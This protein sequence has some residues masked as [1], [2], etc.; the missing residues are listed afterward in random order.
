[1]LRSTPEVFAPTNN[2]K[3]ATDP[4]LE[5]M[6]KQLLTANPDYTSVNPIS[7]IPVGEAT[8]QSVYDDHKVDIKGAPFNN[9]PDPSNYPIS[10]WV[11]DNVSQTL[12]GL[13]RGVASGTERMWDTSL[14]AIH[15]INSKYEDVASEN[16]KMGLMSDGQ[17]GY[18]PML[19]LND[20]DK[21]DLSDIHKQ[22]S[23]ISK[24]YR[25]LYLDKAE[26]TSVGLHNTTSEKIGS[27]LPITAAIVGGTVSGQ[28]EIVGAGLTG[29]FGLS[30]MGEGRLASDN[31]EKQTGVKLDESTKAAVSLGY[32]VVGA[33]PLGSLAKMGG[34]LKFIPKNVVSD[35]IGNYMKNLLKTN[36]ELVSGVGKEIMQS[37][38]QQAPGA[39]KAFMTD[40]AKGTAH[41]AATMSG[42]GAAQNAIDQFIM[43]K[44]VTG[45]DYWN[46]FKSD[47]STGIALAIVTT[48]FAHFKQAAV[49]D[50]ARKQRGEVTLTVN[51]KGQALEIVTDNAGNTIGILPNGKQVK[52]NQA[53][54]DRATTMTYGDFKN[55]TGLYKS[56]ID[57]H[58]NPADFDRTVYGN[59][60]Q[61]TLGKLADK[62]GNVSVATD[63][64]GNNHYIL[65]RNNKDEIIGVNGQGEISPIGK[66]ETPNLT[67][68]NETP[69]GTIVSVKDGKV[70]FETKPIEGQEGLIP[71]EQQTIPI[72]KLQKTT[73]SDPNSTLESAPIGDIHQSI[74]QKYDEGFKQNNPAPE[75][76]PEQLKLEQRNRELSQAQQ[77][78]T[79]I[80]NQHINPDMNAIVTAKVKGEPQY[81]AGG[82]LAFKEDGT[83]DDINSDQTLYHYNFDENGQII[84]VDGKPST[85]PFSI[86]DI[87]EM[88]ENTP[89]E[90]AIQE[91]VALETAPIEARH[92]NE[93]VRPYEVKEEVRINMNGQ[94]ILGTITGV[95]ENGYTFEDARTGQILEVEPRAIINDDNIK[96]LEDE[97]IVTGD[98]KGNLIQGKYSITTDSWSK[99][100]AFIDGTPVPIESIQ[101]IKTA[102]SKLENVQSVETLPSGDS[103]VSENEV[104]P[105]TFKEQIPITET[106]DK[107]GNVIGTQRHFEQVPAEITIGA[108]KESLSPERTQEFVNI[109]IKEVQGQITKVGKV[110]VTGDFDA[111]V[112]AEEASKQE[113]QRLNE[114]LDYWNKVNE[115]LNPVE[116]VEP[117]VDANTDY[118]Q[119]TAENSND[120]A[121]I[122][123]AHND[124]M[125]ESGL[126]TL[127]PWQQELLGMKIHPTS[128]KELG[129][130][131]YMNDLR[132]WFTPKK[133][134]R[135]PN[136]SIDTIAEVLSSH[137][138][139]VTTDM[140]VE[141]MKEHPQ[142]KALR[143]NENTQILDE[144]F[145]K[146]ASKIAGMPIGGIETVSGK[147]F[148]RMYNKPKTE[149]KTAVVE[150]TIEK[151]LEIGNDETVEKNEV[152]F[153]DNPELN[154]FFV[155]R[156]LTPQENEL[157]QYFSSLD[158]EVQPNDRPSEGEVKTAIV[159][160][161]E[162]PNSEQPGDRQQPNIGGTDTSVSGVEAS[163]GIPNNGV[164]KQTE[165]GKSEEV[166]RPE[167]NTEEY[168][169]PEAW[170]KYINSVKDRK[171]ISFPDF[172]RATK[173]EWTDNSNTKLKFTINGKFIGETES[174]LNY[175]DIKEWYKKWV[176]GETN[177]ETT[178]EPT[179]DQQIQSQDI[180][181][182]PT[183]AQKEAGNYK[184]AHVVIQDMDITI[185]NPKG[186]T[187]S[188]VDEDGKAWEHEMNSHYGYFKGTVG[189]DGD[190]VDTF[191]GNNPEGKQIFVIDQIQPKTG[192]FDESKVMLGFDSPEQAKA[193]YLE[194]YD[195]DWKGFYAITEVG[196]DDFKTWLYD[197]KKQHK[198]FA[199]YKDT[200]EAIEKAEQKGTKENSSVLSP[201]NEK[202]IGEKYGIYDGK[203]NKYVFKPSSYLIANKTGL[204]VTVSSIASIKESLER[205]REMNLI[206]K[207]EMLSNTIDYLDTVVELHDESVRLKDVG[208]AER[209]AKQ[210]ELTDKIKN[211]STISEVFD[212]GSDAIKGAFDNLSQGLKEFGFRLETTG[213][214][215]DAINRVADYIQKEYDN[216]KDIKELQ[217]IIPVKE[218]ISLQE[219]T[220]PIK[221]G[222]T[223][224][225]Q[226]KQY[227]V[228]GITTD[229]QTVDLEGN[230][231]TIED[232]DVRELSD[233]LK[234]P[235]TTEEVAQNAVKKLNINSPIKVVKGKQEVMN[236]LI[237][238]GL[239]E[240]DLK[241]HRDFIQ[242]NEV[243]AMNYDGE[244]IINSEMATD[245]KV[246]TKAVL[247]EAVH[248]ATNKTCARAEL[249]KIYDDNIELIRSVIPQTYWN[250]S[251]AQQASEWISIEADSL[252]DYY[253]PEQIA[254]GIKD[255]SL[256]QEVI[257]SLNTLYGNDN[258]FSR[259]NEVSS[260]SN[261]GNSPEVRRTP[262]NE[263]KP[264]LSN[265]NE[266]VGASE[267]SL[268]TDEAARMA[269]LMKLINGEL[270]NEKP[271]DFMTNVER[272]KTSLE[273]PNIFIDG[274]VSDEATLK[275]E[276]PKEKIVSISDTVYG[277]NNRTS[278]DDLWR[279]A[280][281]IRHTKGH[282]VYNIE[283][284]HFAIYKEA[285]H[286]V[287]HIINLKKSFIKYE[288]DGNGA[289]VIIKPL[290]ERFVG[291][292]DW[293]IDDFAR[294]LVDV[295]KYSTEPAQKVINDTLE[296]IEYAKKYYSELAIGKDVWR[297]DASPSFMAFNSNLYT[298]GVEMSQLVLKSG[299]IGFEDYSA[300][301]ID[302][303]GERIKPY[304]KSFYEATR[305]M[306]NADR[307]NMTPTMKV[308]KFDIEKFDA[309]KYK[310]LTQNQNNLPKTDVI[311]QGDKKAFISSIKEKLGVEK[312]NIVAIR[313]IATENGF[314]E[315]KDTTLQEYVELALIEK[316]KEIVSQDLSSEEKYQQVVDLYNAQPTISMRSSER[317]EKQQYSTPLPISFMSGEFI[318][319]I[320]P[321]RVLE[322]SAGNGMMVF[323]VDSRS[324]IANEIDNVRLENLRE[325]PFKEVTN[326][327]G[328]L[329]FNIEPVD[330]V[331]TN[332]PF[333]KS[334]A[335]DYEGYKIAG[336]DEQM[337]VNALSSMK[338]DGRASIIIGGH[339]KYKENG[340]LA[341]EK[342]FLNYLYDKYNVTDIINIDGGLYSKQGTSF[343]VRLILINGRRTGFE[344]LQRRYA[345][346]KQNAK[347]EPVKTFDE[348]Y[349][350]I[351][352]H[353]NNLLHN[354]IS[355]QPDNGIQPTNG[356]GT[357]IQTGTSTA[358]RPG[359]TSGG[360]SGTPSSRPIENGG[361][362][363]K[364]TKPTPIND[365][366]G[367][368]AQPIQ[369]SGESSISESTTGTT[370]RVQ[371]QNAEQFLNRS[372]ARPE[373]LKV[374]L[375]AE[376]SP[377][378]S[379]SK[380]EPIGSVVP[381]NVAQ[382]LNDILHKFKD[383]DSYVQTKLG[384][385][386]KEELFGAL[387]AEQID[388][389]AMAI[390]QIEEGKALI[391]GDMTGIG[392]GRQAAAIIRYAALSGKKP[393]FVTEKAALFS[394][395]YRDL[396]DIGS[397]DLVPFIVNSKGKEDPSMTDENG[398]VIYSPLSD[399][400][401][402]SVIES[403]KL[404]NNYDYAVLTYSQLNGNEK[405][406][407]LSPKQY[408]FRNIAVDNILILDESHNAGGEGNTGK[409][410]TETLPLT[411]GVTFLSGTFAKRAD[412]MPIY[413]MKT[414]MNEANMSETELITAIQTGGI[415]LQE[416][417][418]KNLTEVGQMIRRE[419]DFTGVNI[420][421]QTMTG[422]KDAHYKTFD[423]VIDV[424][425]QLIH[426]QKDFVDPIIEDLNASLAGEQGGAETRRGTEA[427]GI[428]N[429]PFASKT[430]NLVRQML[431]SLKAKEVANEA[432]KELQAGRKPVIAIGNTMGAFL[433][434]MGTV[435]DVVDNHDYSLT[436]M[437]GLTGLFRIT[438]SDAQGNKV[439]RDLGKDL[440]SSEG[441][442]KYKELEAKIKKLSSG[443]SISPID[444]IK[445]EIT[446][447]GFTVG[448]MTGRDNELVFNEN[449][450]ATISRR[451]NTDK[452]KLARD[453]NA[454]D[455]DVLI[456]NQA[457]STGI[458]LH[459]SSKFKDQRQRIM[460]FAQNQLDVN[461]EV[462]MRGRIDRTGQVLRGAYRYII[463]PIPAEQRMIMMFKAKLKSLDANTTSSQKSKTNE[464]AI[465]DFLNKYGDEIVIEYLKENPDINEKM[466]DP[467]QFEGKSEEDLA[468]FTK[469]EGASN[470]V[471]G[472]AALLSVKEQEAF[473]N[474][475][476]E[477]YT[478]LINYLNDS[479]TN[480]L[481][482]TTLPL[483]AETKAKHIVVQG[484]NS[485]N[486]FSEDSIRE[487][488]EVD[489]LKKPMSIKEVNEEIQ[490]LTNGLSQR[491]YKD[492]LVQKM[493]DY[494]QAQTEAETQKVTEDY[495][496]KEK[497]YFDKADKEADKLQLTGDAKAEFLDTKR[498]DWDNMVRMHID[499]K[500]NVIRQR[501][502]SIIRSFNSLPAG[503]VMMI[504]SSLEI[505]TDTSYTE[506]MFLGFRMKDKL[507]P[508][509][510]TAVFAPLDSRR[511]IDVPLSKVAFIQAAY[512]ETMQNVRYIK[513]TPENWDSMIPTKTRRTAYI[514]TGNILQAYGQEGLKG[515][516]VSYSTIDGQIKQ[517]I[518]LNEKYKASEQTMRVQVIDKLDE[519]RRGTN[520]LLVDTS[521]GVSIRKE[522]NNYSIS[523][524]LSKVRGGKYFLDAG[525]R[526][527][528]Y[529]NDFRQ[530]AGQM[531]GVVSE[532]NIEKTLRYLSDKFNISVDAGM[533]EVKEP[534][535]MVL[536]ERGATSLDK[537]EGLTV[538]EIAKSTGTVIG[539]K[540][541]DEL[542]N[543]LTGSFMKINGF[544]WVEAY[545]DKFKAVEIFLNEL[546][547]QG[548]EIPE[549]NDFYLQATHLAGKNTAQ[550][551]MY[552]QRF[553][554]PLIDIIEQITA[555]GQSYRDLENYVMLKHGLERNE[556]MRNAEA[557]EKVDKRL[558]YPS[559]EAIEKD[560]DGSVM[561][562][563]NAT[564]EQMLQDELETLAEKDYSGI[565]AINEETETTPEYFIE[566]FEK[567][568][569][570][571]ILWE[572]INKATNFGLKK[573]L[574]SGR[575]NKDAYNTYANRFKYFV[576]L[577]GF[578][579]PIA[580]DI[581]DYTPEMGTYFAAPIIKANGRVSRAEQPFAY[582]YQM[583]QS[584]ISEGN[585]NELNQTMRRLAETDKT[586]IITINKAW[587]ELVGEEDGQPIYEPRT[588]EYSPNPEQYQKNQDAFEEKMQ[589]MAEDGFAI[590]RSKRLN[591][592]LFT[593]PRQAVQHEIRVYQNG[594]EKVIYINANPKV[595]QA[596]NGTNVVNTGE[597]YQKYVSNP[598]RWIAAN[599]TSR[600]PLF[601]VTNFE[602][603]YT[604][605]STILMVKEDAKYALE[606]QKNIVKG[607][608]A[609]WRT[610][611]KK[612]NIANKYDNYAAEFVLNGGKTGYSHIVELDKVGK[613]IQKE[614]KNHKRQNKAGDFV[615]ALGNVNEFIENLTRFSVYVTSRE[616]GRSVV[617]SVED[618]KN[619][620]VNFNQTGSGAMGA[621]YFKGGY[622]FLN[623]AFQAFENLI[624]VASNNK[625][626]AL[627]LFGSFIA[628]GMLAPLLAGLM[629]GD[630]A[631]EAYANLTD[632]QRRNYFQLWTGNGFLAW[633]L[634]QELR[635]FY[636]MGDHT[637]MALTGRRK[638]VESMLGV[639]GSL[640]DLLPVNPTSS[641]EAGWAVT[642]PTLISI[643]AQ[644][645]TNTNFMGGAIYKEFKDPNKPGF[646]NARTNKRG[647]VLTPDAIVQF[648][649]LVDGMTLG[650]GVKPG[651]I[652]PN[653]D[654]VNHVLRGAFGGLYTLASQ[655]I[656]TA[657]KG[658]R[659]EEIKL[660]DTPVKNFFTHVDEINQQP[661]G[662]N[663]EYFKVSDKV[664][665][666]N[667]YIKGYQEELQQMY[668]A[669]ADSLTL[670]NYSKNIVD[671][672]TP[673][674]STLDGVVKTINKQNDLLKEVPDEVKPKIEERIRILK[675]LAID[676]SKTENAEE[677]KTLRA[678]AIRKFKE[679]E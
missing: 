367:S 519:L 28:P 395:I 435:G 618:A 351:K 176:S 157:D 42:I 128:F 480:D 601:V 49:L 356:N 455:I 30:M 501:G 373:P 544:K 485:G 366:G 539:D 89:R 440:L 323:N 121:E 483:R 677:I 673:Q 647:E 208:E 631:E 52:V 261:E 190:H 175:K 289:P 475:I 662:M 371:P 436:L 385:E 604:F 184:K 542:Q 305:Y 256:P 55:Y 288:K 53:D 641:I 508:S 111:L 463:S 211:A 311:L 257:N 460:L 83:I 90:Q 482:I 546:R 365:A 363:N 87:T 400:Q 652:S 290:A 386:S 477:K 143:G 575:L 56:G 325:Q 638:P 168:D 98:N 145:R 634:P 92:A 624:R 1:M 302:S 71:S 135:T 102:E 293:T 205:M 230:G 609:I 438:E 487:T 582:I 124:A 50:N 610:I 619:V 301:M 591:V 464:I 382:T 235:E 178:T 605:A 507:T 396:R 553:H 183:E 319:G 551:E 573:S 563:Y 346:L 154:P 548:V 489:V 174:D 172:L 676:V 472:R 274:I 517:G 265:T 577:R 283:N 105:Q 23:E 158:G 526:G 408:F 60:L 595:A 156:E 216:V 678:E 345:P 525:L 316:A 512:S 675:Q 77:Q 22:Q 177:F 417:M 269:E 486:P 330:A 509:T 254:E 559:K 492:M 164:E 404:P 259:K 434:E 428:S 11:G 231:E 394:D 600:N 583:A 380:S 206:L 234:Q 84:M 12:G 276:K 650:D 97:A 9:T 312:L 85:T 33:L 467:F 353:E 531:V 530:L 628:A 260:T 268:S 532:N 456:L 221:N 558:K 442:A 129:D 664:K 118:Y 317:I 63:S 167:H 252:T 40:L 391:I 384:Y 193:A 243:V 54:I 13:M 137:G 8:P 280:Y 640:T 199:E 336:L 189:R 503:R 540:V 291:D 2:I 629:G 360:Q 142:N 399:A 329:E 372:D 550:L 444:V 39:A 57:L 478:T 679:T 496:K 580:E 304:L 3:A 627:A 116:I 587:Y 648:T 107:K 337:V 418:S 571:D 347:S 47:V 390:Y 219:G 218:Q 379:R 421:W 130:R 16:A 35:A 88:G 65:G 333:G 411:K 490:K 264:G 151:Q 611:N 201:E 653:P 484:K 277:D 354:G 228:N 350:R 15:D 251:K 332:P 596:V 253:T 659:G 431:F 504:P 36:P 138:V 521:N 69:F 388:S 113:T 376:K 18:I 197:G 295:K 27:F 537:A 34:V 72:S 7:S 249:A 132:S 334:E 278:P 223:V 335:R 100:I 654:M 344:A 24:A 510:I 149:I 309:K 557:A 204:K 599:M 220:Q 633:S 300:Q 322:P 359:G 597:A 104:V 430:F 468:N 668:K 6:D 169:D 41:S 470:K 432:I 513:A 554:D 61:Q 453:F 298:M 127:L 481:E 148:L 445:A 446:K 413:A 147:V 370:R 262:K 561:D 515:Q 617:R 643:P 536:G 672:M 443:I 665:A 375:E 82:K 538:S 191:I 202:L 134:Q 402:K 357:S 327:D 79:D 535:F 250:K 318:N 555:K 246:I 287:K 452:K 237:E 37:W 449:G 331:V 506:G 361:Q 401:K 232:I 44:H 339:T 213:K 389:V 144:R 461:T 476:T 140:I 579:K 31:Y 488:V 62:N 374:D 439:H 46:R 126:E 636:A 139:E 568:G 68:G 313:K 566:E 637:Y 186:S 258:H 181:T 324:V 170:I 574:D 229:G 95:T 425:N 273:K 473:Y 523:V 163:N 528:V 669:G 282:P 606:F 674:H 527:L 75:P 271:V 106:K 146:V 433:N 263:S 78:A 160:S 179:V 64:Q 552:E 99:G 5:E 667:T 294:K 20:Q 499:Q 479:G 655:S 500:N 51:D 459:A 620:T 161:S 25:Q 244:I 26:K 560:I 248:E 73:F 622:V 4:Q 91:A 524:P 533:K 414:S 364:P 518:L 103:K 187:R 266:V 101:P 171:E 658:V 66:V 122:V 450:T 644:L 581:F 296:A 239:S 32:G 270:D 522:G 632:Y 613:R 14:S 212:F 159:P 308:D 217:G 646:K 326:Q 153:I 626:K 306:P 340:T 381:T 141:F 233:N 328:T 226:G 639:L 383:I 415:P 564:R 236:V 494:V 209:A 112:A 649:K 242:L 405:K 671:L 247:H 198:P 424:F 292:F 645:E 125:Q 602:R 454:G 358:N 462:Q 451:T 588:A 315:I 76:S 21:K 567:N 93:S 423:G 173:S 207:N 441:Q 630:D 123:Q 590:Q 80:I 303:F 416:I 543:K 409:F 284:I 514:V 241:V 279:E 120:I 19:G 192:K 222:S 70:T 166:K 108:L 419:R 110:K 529:Q 341:G 369:G 398:A 660:K 245:E 150:K 397:A 131:N 48:P 429:T 81:L 321:S 59:R 286:Y 314:G 200:P 576:P 598:T 307:A 343:P 378:P 520:G 255:I 272:G 666:Q 642:M 651:F 497:A 227:T 589:K 661:S 426:F 578:D 608:E 621:A 362:S 182:T 392:K 136:N 447:A 349:T 240:N 491:D 502:N 584:A 534:D 403:G 152:D 422:M 623:V 10:D 569:L 133:T 387:A 115:K 74:M 457:A 420:D 592:G 320:N 498:Q 117:K 585:K 29:A 406:N 427:L 635:V 196:V 410:M 238:K 614:I 594:V 565:T 155:G 162:N 210:Q 616:M 377:Y 448:E 545:Q 203:P 607:R 281:S 474:E 458:S 58:A 297:T 165:T 114:Q 188:G 185:E 593:K 96:G 570:T 670:A 615:E 572:R 310:K 656:S 562:E 195:K 43:G 505:G 469:Q 67:V 495:Q 586:G 94:P 541:R 493:N 547:K 338:E 412:N 225:Y 466:L 299:K 45:Q 267:T 393:I 285:G 38:S 465:V 511:R 215:K 275:Y 549:E 180:N 194:N 407:G 516:L 471:A 119:R 342:A 368:N 86:G 603:D 214:L 355:V 612:G 663:S 556:Y 625:G 437:R 224:T 17:G 352:T 348:L 109:K 657:E